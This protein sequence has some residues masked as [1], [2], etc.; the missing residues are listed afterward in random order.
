MSD[1][2]SGE[3]EGREREDWTPENIQVLIASALDTVQQPYEGF[4]HRLGTGRQS[5]LRLAAAVRPLTKHCG[6]CGA[7]ALR[8]TTDWHEQD[9]DSPFFAPSALQGENPK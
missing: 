6:Y 1:L 7:S 8:E 3:P 4:G 9:C 5:L 2:T